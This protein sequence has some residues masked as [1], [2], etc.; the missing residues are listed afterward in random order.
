LRSQNAEV[1][2]YLPLYCRLPFYCPHQGPHGLFAKQD[3]C[4][5]PGMTSSLHFY[6]HKLGSQSFSRVWRSS[7][8]WRR[9]ELAA[10]PN[11]CLPTLVHAAED[12]PGGEAFP[13]HF[14]S[15]SRHQRKYNPGEL[16][17]LV[18]IIRF[19]VKATG[20]VHTLSKGRESC[21]ALIQPAGKRFRVSGKKHFRK[22]K[23]NNSTLPDSQ[24]YQA[25]E[26]Q[27]YCPKE[28][29][30]AVPRYTRLRVVLE[31]SRKK[32]F[33]RRKETFI[34]CRY[35]TSFFLQMKHVCCLYMLS[36][37]LLLRQTKKIICS[38]AI[39]RRQH[40]REGQETLRVIRQRVLASR[41]SRTWADG[42]RV[43]SWCASLRITLGVREKLITCRRDHCALIARSTIDESVHEL[44]FDWPTTLWYMVALSVTLRDS[45]KSVEMRH[46]HCLS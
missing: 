2:G 7:S 15:F 14:P 21:P 17:E 28:E 26:S 39:C 38:F 40:M 35:R 41:L 29:A 46:I 34:R 22:S 25:H 18:S 5:Q 9:F 10:A 30:R 37:G 33:H 31:V 19:A 24:K 3:A 12:C 43:S 4:Q 13:Q 20:S 8:R 45:K 16:V 1:P 42:T 23:Q 36:A 11:H 44:L 6:S 32:H 27:E